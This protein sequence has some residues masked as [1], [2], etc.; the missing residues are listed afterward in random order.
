M[1]FFFFINLLKIIR[2]YD[3]KK[4]RSLKVKG[5]MSGSN[6][7]STAI[8]VAVLIVIVI[9]VLIIVFSCM[10]IRNHISRTE[11]GTGRRERS[12]WW[13][14]ILFANSDNKGNDVTV[15][16]AGVRKSGGGKHVHFSD[17]SASGEEDI[18][19]GNDDAC[20][21]AQLISKPDANFETFDDSTYQQKD[22]LDGGG[23]ATEGAGGVSQMNAQHFFPK[24]VST[25]E[26]KAG[27]AGEAA[28]MT[29][30]KLVSAY[31]ESNGL[32][33]GQSNTRDK[34]RNRHSFGM[35]L[36]NRDDTIQLRLDQIRK[37]KL[38]GTFKCVQFNES[39][40]IC[41]D[42]RCTQD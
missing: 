33:M 14:N 34:L 20:P 37:E 36:A 13:N 38:D 26:C 32:M 28:T 22:C 27:E 23:S 16:H 17:A 42:D 41:G 10:G 7:S 8:V 31:K 39:P 9:F 15:K 5:T 3:Q 4:N 25:G 11:C 40:L 35:G 29:Y 1:V 30:D 19:S 12:S 18:E 2:P 6:S 21:V 24:V